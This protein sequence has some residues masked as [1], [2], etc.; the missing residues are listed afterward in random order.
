MEARRKG[1]RYIGSEKIE[2]NSPLIRDEINRQVRPLLPQAIFRIVHGLYLRAALIQERTSTTQTGNRYSL[3]PHSPRKYFRT[4]LTV[5]GVQQDYIDYMMGHVT[6]TYLSL[7]G[8]TEHLRTIYARSGL[9]IRSQTEW[10][11]VDQVK[12]FMKSLGLSPEQYLIQDAVAKPHRTIIDGNQEETNQLEILREAIKK[13]LF[14][15]L[16]EQSQKGII[17]HTEK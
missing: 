17:S 4:Q 12:A 10:S 15:E 3:R 8:P 5:L 16:Q 2:D 1:T 9:S 11:K 6:D 7:K 14:N 13:A